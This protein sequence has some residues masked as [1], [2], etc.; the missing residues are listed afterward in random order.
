MNENSDAL[1]YA[2]EELKDDFSIVAEAVFKQ[3]NTLLHLNVCA[4]NNCELVLAALA[5][6]K[7]HLTCALMSSEK[8]D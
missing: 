8:A 7:V 6:L 2:S 1:Q 3:G 5:I 4:K